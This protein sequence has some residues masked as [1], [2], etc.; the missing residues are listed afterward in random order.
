MMTP[1]RFTLSRAAA[2]RPK[3][4]SEGRNEYM[5][6][7]NIFA[8]TQLTLFIPVRSC[9]ASEGVKKLKMD[10]RPPGGVFRRNLRAHPLKG[11]RQEKKTSR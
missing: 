2:K 1:K 9:T 7:L 8:V 6:Y 11:T 10:F 4:P 3:G 5:A